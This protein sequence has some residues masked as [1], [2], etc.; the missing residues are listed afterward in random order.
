MRLHKEDFEILKVI[1]R[2]AFGEVLYLLDCS[3]Y[4]NTLIPA[5]NLQFGFPLFSFVQE[6]GVVGQSEAFL[7]SCVICSVCFLSVC[8]F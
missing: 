7:H 2:G 5:E 6:P 4:L 8:L 1:G 3:L